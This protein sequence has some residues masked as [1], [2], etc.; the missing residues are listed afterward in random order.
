MGTT[1]AG[2][3]NDTQ[4]IFLAIMVLGLTG[5]LFLIVFG[6]L[7]DNL[8][9]TDES[10]TISGEAPATINAAGYTLTGA[11][12]GGAGSFTITTVLNTTN[13]TGGDPQGYN[14]TILA[15]NYTVSSVGT[16]TNATV[17][18]FGNVSISYT[19][20]RNVQ[21]E[22]DTNSVITNLSEGATTFFTF[23]NVWFTLLAIVLLIII[24]ISVI[25]VVSPSG[26]G[27]F[28]N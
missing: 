8:G 26:K 11:S 19:Y 12:D 1:I 9:F 5:L 2:R 10:V 6:N 27:G 7:T 15:A 16:V 22:V 3:V 18:N 20:S 24:V 21:G 14:I 17:T 28:S 13:E 4:R 23:S 25:Q